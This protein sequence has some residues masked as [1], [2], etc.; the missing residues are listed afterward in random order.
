MGR[1][2]RLDT[3]GREGF[4]Y[5]IEAV[6]QDLVKI[7][8]SNNPIRRLWHLQNTNPYKLRLVLT[9]AGPPKLE[10]HWHGRFGLLRVRGEWFL[11][12]GAL[13]RL[14]AVVDTAFIPEDARSEDEWRLYDELHCAAMRRVD[15][16]DTKQALDPR[17]VEVPRESI[18]PRPFEQESL[19]DYLERT[20]AA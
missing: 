5:V 11:R 9:V 6:G 3:R 10:Q 17:D 14:L 13:A 18:M 19:L 20:E 7:G 15:V 4:V 1:G 12:E 2:A 16:F 8:Y